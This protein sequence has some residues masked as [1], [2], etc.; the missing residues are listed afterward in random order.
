VVNGLGERV[1]VEEEHVFPLRKSSDVANGR[2]AIARAMIVPQRSLGE[3][4]T[5]LRRRAPKTWAYLERHDALLAA[6]KSSIYDRRPPFSI[7]GVG[8]YSFAPFKV[9]VSGL[10]KRYAFSLVAPVDGRPVVLDDTCY[11]LP[12]ER[13][14]AATRA[15]EALRSPLAAEF[16]AARTF[17]DAKRPISKAIL[18]G[19]DLR[20]LRAQMESAENAER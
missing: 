4:T 19:L 12:F 14:D 20:A 5:R 16:F 18:Q 8:P 11:F 6:R 13:E 3:D 17:W 1:Q 2:A 15:L 9:A 7:F 10:Y